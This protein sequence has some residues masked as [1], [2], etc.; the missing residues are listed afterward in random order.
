MK[1]IKRG[2]KGQPKKGRS[3][4]R[5]RGI[6]IEAQLVMRDRAKK[7]KYASGRP[8]IWPQTGAKQDAKAEAVLYMKVVNGFEIMQM[9]STKEIM[10]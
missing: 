6:N 3:R 4:H 5:A 2:Y 7:Q 8:V 1:N 9:R 10:A